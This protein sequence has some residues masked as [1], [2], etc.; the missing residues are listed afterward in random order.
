MLPQVNK[1]KSTQHQEGAPF[2]QRFD[3]APWPNAL[4]VSSFLASVILVGAGVVVAK[5]IPHGTRVPFA[6]TFGTLVAFVPPAIALFAVLFIVAGYELE[7]GRLR[8]RR[9]LWST[10]IPLAGLHRVHADPGIMK[11]SL[12]LFGNG[13]LYSVTGIYQNRT[14]GRYRAFVTDPKQAVAL[15]LPTRIVVISPANTQMFVYTIHSRFPS[16]KIGPPNADSGI[17]EDH[18]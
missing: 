5:V 15:F 14:L 16:V 2:M 13:G 11:G 1:T 10:W 18:A 6:E 8:I 12:R 4:K 3:A 17:K 9:L 7:P